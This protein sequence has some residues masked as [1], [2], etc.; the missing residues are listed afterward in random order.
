[1]HPTSTQY[2]ARED[3]YID[4]GDAGPE[5]GTTALVHRCPGCIDVV[6]QQDPAPPHA[7]RPDHLEGVADVV[8]AFAI[9]EVHLRRGGA[10]ALQRKRVDSNASPASQGTH[11][12]L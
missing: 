12:E 10:G 6:E 11:Q 9:A 1:M 3:E 8:L 5:Q 4:P 7:L 2:G